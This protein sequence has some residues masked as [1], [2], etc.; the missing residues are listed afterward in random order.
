MERNHACGVDHSEPE[1]AEVSIAAYGSG[2][3]VWIRLGETPLTELAVPQSNIRVRVAKNG[4]ASFEDILQ[5]PSGSLL[6]LLKLKLIEERSA[7][8]GMVRVDAPEQSVPMYSCQ[9][10]IRL[11]SSIATSGWIGTR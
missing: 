6:G 4:Y 11:T 10:R 9:G 2:P 3:A 1:G 8:A 5:F 7:L